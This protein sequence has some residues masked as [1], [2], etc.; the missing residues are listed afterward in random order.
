MTDTDIISFGNGLRLCAV[1]TDRFKTRR[2][3]V[4]TAV[5]LRSE[6]AAA[7][8]LLPYLL[9]RTCRQFPQPSL[10][11]RRLAELYGAELS[12]SVTKLGE[13]QLLR[14]QIS[15]IDD[16]FALQKENVAGA[17]AELLAS[18][19]FDPALEGGRFG[20]A[21]IT[22]EKRLLLERLDSEQNDKRRYALK[23]C[24]ALMCEGEA[25]GLDVLGTCEQI[26][27][28]TAEAVTEAYRTLL[29][30]A[31]IQITTVGSTD[32]AR[33]ADKLREGFLSV[34]RENVCECRSQIIPRA[35][36][37]REFEEHLPITQA[38]LVMGLRTG[39]AEPDEETIQTR[40]MTDIF[41]GGP[42][43][44]LFANVREKMSLCYYCSARYQA[45]KGVIFVQSGIEAKNR[46]KAITEIKRQ[47]ESIRAGKVEAKDFEASKK[48]LT[49]AYRGVDDSPEGIDMWYC[50]QILSPRPLSPEE[51]VG[52]INSVTPE[53]VTRAAE[54]VT[55]DT[56]YVLAGEGESNGNE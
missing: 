56:I 6:T 49:D 47:L 37:V 3:S 12:A 48:G 28:L 29:R 20:E 34:Q 51:Y 25:Y 55:L 38:K 52:R 46:D 4:T 39:V 14:L 36:K 45:H 9:H 1:K 18:L 44:L 33:A 24:E 35:E 5:P 13:C 21:D 53:Q 22:R 41:G 8:A 54:K 40:V 23:R 17:C 31:K 16:R 2:I 32:P 42:Y 7:Y 50:S 10:L 27:A 26:Q 19:I 15:A 11:N 43:S 30:T